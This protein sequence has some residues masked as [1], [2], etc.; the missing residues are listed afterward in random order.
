MAPMRC[1]VSGEKI[2]VTI[3]KEDLQDAFSRFGTVTDVWVARQPPGFA[4]VTF[5]D[6]RDGEDA[7]KDM[8]NKEILGCPVRIE[9]SRGKSGGARPRGDGG[10]G[11]GGGCYGGGG[12]RDSK[13]EE[14][15]D[16]R[17]GLCNR[18]DSCRYS[19]G[20]DGG[21]PPA[22][23][24]RAA[25]AARQRVT[26]T[27]D[28]TAAP[29]LRGAAA[30]VTAA[31]TAAATER[32]FELW[33]PPRLLKPVRLERGRWFRQSATALSFR[34]PASHNRSTKACPPAHLPAQPLACPLN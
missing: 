3:D 7:I 13:Q 5:E 2:G 10:R 22:A 32:A 29:R 16:F 12:N 28:P 1:Y 26:A 14:C 30:A 27:A 19:H 6:S 11:G 9:E 4:F 31:G 24:P 23:T 20:P 18:G 34:P 25:T 33:R 17:R 21:A 8:Q 15:A